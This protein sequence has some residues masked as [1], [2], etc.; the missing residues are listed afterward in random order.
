MIE[1]SRFIFPLRSSTILTAFGISTAAW[2]AL[3]LTALVL[4]LGA[5]AIFALVKLTFYAVLGIALVT[6]WGGLIATVFAFFLWEKEPLSML[7]PFVWGFGFLLSKVPPYLKVED[8]FLH[9]M[10]QPARDVL[11]YYIVN[12]WFYWVWILA[13]ISLSLAVFTGLTILIARHLPELIRRL[14]RNFHD[15]TECHHR[16]RPLHVCSGC[17]ATEDDLRPSGYGLLFARCTEC[18]QSLPTMDFSGRSELQCRCARC[19]KDSEEPLLGR[20]PVWHVAMIHTDRDA[21]PQTNLS[22]VGNRLVFLHESSIGD[23]SDARRASSLGYLDLLDQVIVLGDESSLSRSMK[24]LPAML[25]TLERG[26]TVDVRRDNA[27]PFT[28]VRLD[29][30]ELRPLP[31][32]LEGSALTSWRNSLASSFQK[33]S[34]WSG[35]VDEHSLALLVCT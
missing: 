35:K 8:D 22:Q 31:T 32:H 10:S 2:I 6:F 20:V 12:D 4:F 30:G 21:S 13:A 9:D 18:G 26:T 33:I 7:G 29:S 27:M 24:L 5:C 19:K 1:R 25:N 15:C 34:A 16:G 17:G 28:V 3:P 14:R 23:V 11:E